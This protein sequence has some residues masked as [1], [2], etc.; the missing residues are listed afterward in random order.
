VGR[1]FYR[2]FNRFSSQSPRVITSAALAIRRHDTA[3]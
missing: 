1:V 3:A 2:R